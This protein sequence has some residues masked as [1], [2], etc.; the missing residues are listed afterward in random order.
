MKHILKQIPEVNLRSDNDERCFTV[1][2]EES[3]NMMSSFWV[4]LPANATRGSV[5]GPVAD[6]LLREFLVHNHHC[7]DTPPDV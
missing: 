3:S 1:I 6:K 7:E 5:I 4:Q 2:L